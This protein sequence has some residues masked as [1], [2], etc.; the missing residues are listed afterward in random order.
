M[1]EAIIAAARGRLISPPF[2]D[3]TGDVYRTPEAA[4][5]AIIVELD[6]TDAERISMGGG[7]IASAELRVEI[8]AKRDD[9]SLLTPTPA[10]TAEGMARLAA[11]V[12]T[13]ILAPPS[14]LSGLAWSI[15]P[16]GYEFETER[17]ETPLARATQS[18]ALQ[19][20]QP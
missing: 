8:L 3:A 6:Y 11:L 5:P 18:F 17:G 14:D 15:A 4:L 19:I 2:S 12:R 9:W 16:A 13:A 20:L 10:N 1:S 7:F